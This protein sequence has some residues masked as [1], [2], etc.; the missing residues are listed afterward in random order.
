MHVLFLLSSN[1]TRFR[2]GGGSFVIRD[3]AAI[4]SSRLPSANLDPAPS[5][6]LRQIILE[7]GASSSS[8][9]RP[10]R[11]R[12]DDEEALL[13]LLRSGACRM[14]VRRMPAPDGGAGGKTTE[15]DGGGGV[16]GVCCKDKIQ[17]A[18]R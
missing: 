12:S 4:R 3:D 18:A 16:V 6:F 15:T 8:S 13:A 1:E 17:I 7:R 5:G 14:R 10:S 2:V 11:D 9:S